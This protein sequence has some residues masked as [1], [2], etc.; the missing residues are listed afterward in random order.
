[1]TK[2]NGV[3]DLLNNATPPIDKQMEV[4]IDFSLNTEIRVSNVSGISGR[5]CLCISVQVDTAL[6]KG[7]LL[8]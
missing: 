7:A 4:H 1:M 2:S 3:Y 5:A 8:S 6:S